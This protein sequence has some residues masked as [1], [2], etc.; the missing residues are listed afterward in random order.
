MKASAMATIFAAKTRGVWLRSRRLI[1]C[2]TLS[3]GAV[4]LT[5]DQDGRVDWFRSYEDVPATTGAAIQK[6]RAS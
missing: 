5:K 2:T 6:E 1:D 3:K 4:V